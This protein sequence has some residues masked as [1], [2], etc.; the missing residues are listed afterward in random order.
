MKQPQAISVNLLFETDNVL[1]SIAKIIAHTF[2][3]MTKIQIDEF[4][5]QVFINNKYATEQ[6]V[7]ACWINCIDSDKYPST[8]NKYITYLFIDDSQIELAI[9]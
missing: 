7:S 2:T 1:A 5:K 6:L 9:Y 3:D 8:S 4:P